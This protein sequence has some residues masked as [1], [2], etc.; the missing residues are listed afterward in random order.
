MTREERKKIE[1]GLIEFSKDKNDPW[2][3]VFERTLVICGGKPY[4][5]DRLDE[6]LI[7]LY[8]DRRQQYY[9]CNSMKIQDDEFYKKKRK[10]KEI[11]LVEAKKLNLL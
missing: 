9:I 7:L 1:Q 2:S 3:T 4:L 8:A 11:A 5:G 10:I 6:L